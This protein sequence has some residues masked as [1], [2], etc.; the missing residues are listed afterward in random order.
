MAANPSIADLSIPDTESDAWR[1]Q[2][3][4]WNQRASLNYVVSPSC[5]AA[6]KSGDGSG[7]DSENRHCTGEAGVF[8]LDLTLLT[9]PRCDLGPTVFELWT[10]RSLRL[11]KRLSWSHHFRYRPYLCG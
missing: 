10:S 6:P 11:R 2:C 8:Q 1:L 7:D 4:K 5:S 3:G 9:E